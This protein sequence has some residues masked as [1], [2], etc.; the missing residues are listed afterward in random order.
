MLGAQFCGF[1]EAKPL[2]IVEEEALL[3]EDEINEGN[4]ERELVASGARR[5][6]G[7]PRKS[8]AAKRRQWLPVARLAG[9]LSFVYHTIAFI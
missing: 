1:D 4:D 5:N 7:R 3:V 8:M 9:I 2:T 6:K